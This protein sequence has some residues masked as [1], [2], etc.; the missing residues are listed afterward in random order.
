VFVV[1]LYLQLKLKNPFFDL[2]L[3][4]GCGF[5]RTMVIFFAW[6]NNSKWNGLTFKAKAKF[7]GKAEFP[8]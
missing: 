1:C 7:L 8:S 5:F 2:R 3:N 4:F 6:F